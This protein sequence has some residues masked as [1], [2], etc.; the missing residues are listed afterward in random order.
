MVVMLFYIL[1]KKITTLKIHVAIML[2][3]FVAGNQNVQS[4]GNL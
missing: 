4:W 3:L 2:P 1:Q